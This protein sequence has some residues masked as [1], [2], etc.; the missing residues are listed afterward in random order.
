MINLY[1]Y[2]VMCSLFIIM[3]AKILQITLKW[4]TSFP[5]SQDGD[6]NINCLLE[7]GKL[8]STVYFR[9]LTFIN[10]NLYKCNLF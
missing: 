5:P 4:G 10:D 2:F 7:I 9:Q 6:V 1:Y 3:R 8:I